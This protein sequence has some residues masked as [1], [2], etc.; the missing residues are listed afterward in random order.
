MLRLILLPL[1]LWLLLSSC[2]PKTEP[3][4]LLG[5]LNQCIFDAEQQGRTAFQRIQFQIERK[6][7][8]Q[9]VL[10]EARK[11]EKEIEATRKKMEGIHPDSLQ[12]GWGQKMLRQTRARLLQGSASDSLD[13]E[14]EALFTRI[15]SRKPFSH[16]SLERLALQ[17]ELLQFRNRIFLRLN[18]LVGNSGWQLPVTI[19]DQSTCG[20]KKISLDV[21]SRRVR[22]WENPIPYIQSLTR[23]GV[24]IEVEPSFEIVNTKCRI[25]FDSLA[26]GHYEI[27]GQDYHSDW[28]G[29]RPFRFRFRI[30]PDGSLDEKVLA[31]Y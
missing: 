11:W 12:R 5:I 17:L 28:Q 16:D 27:R 14:S 21:K 9:I 8:Y 2:Q 6:P 10:T 29:W 19:L 15:V 23:N 4:P 22:E 3:E 18:E 30:N 13:P 1:F 31:A 25:G 24:P 20:Q 7:K 26:P